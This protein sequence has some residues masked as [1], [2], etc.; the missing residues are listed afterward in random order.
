MVMNTKWKTNHAAQNLKRLF[1][2]CA[3][4]KKKS[5]ILSSNF[6]SL[7]EVVAWSSSSV[8]KSLALVAIFFS[9]EFTTGDKILFM[10]SDGSSDE[11][12]FSSGSSPGHSLLNLLSQVMPLQDS[13]KLTSFQLK[14]VNLS[15]NGASDELYRDS[16]S[17]NSSTN[18]GIENEIR[19]T[20]EETFQVKHETEKMK[21]RSLNPEESLTFMTWDCG[22]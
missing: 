8:W 21:E 22:E 15:S 20:F 13:M 19:K 6:Q 16:Q 14:N 18:Q 12:N 11:N 7:E 4:R 10:D 1:D 9:L 17:A 5:R 2:D 3:W